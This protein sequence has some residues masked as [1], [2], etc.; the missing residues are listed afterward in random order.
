MMRLRAVQRRLRA[1]LAVTG[2]VAAVAAVILGGAAGASAANQY[3]TTATVSDLRFTTATIESGTIAQ[4]TGNWSLPDSPATPAGFTVHLPSELQGR[5]DHFP[6]IDPSGATMGQ[7]TVSSTE[8][9]CAI[10]TDYIRTHPRN[11][12]GTFT[13]AVSVQTIVTKPTP[14][15]Y[16]FD[17]STTT[18]TVT[19]PQ[20]CSSD[21]TFT[22]RGSGKVGYFHPDGN[23]IEWQVWVASGAVGMKGGEQVVVSDTPDQNQEL[24]DNINGTTY[25]W[26]GSTTTIAKDSTGKEQPVNF[27]P[28]AEGTYNHTAASVSFTA[29]QGRYYQVTFATRITD[30][31]AAGTYTNDASVTIDG[32]KDPVTATV[33]RQAGGG[34]GAGDAVGT[35]TWSKN[36]ATDTAA[37]GGSTWLVSGANNI[38]RTVTDNAQNDGNPA[39]GELETG[40]LPYGQYTLTEQTAPEGYQT[41]STPHAFTIDSDHTAINLG[42]ITNSRLPGSVSWTKTDQA[43]GRVLDGSTWTLTGPDGSTEIAD[44]G[45]RDTDDKSG[46]FTVTALPWGP[47]TLTEK[48]APA[49]YEL[50][51][52]PHTFTIAA[53]SLTANLGTITN[54]A[55]VAVTPTP[56]PTPSQ[57]T[58]PARP[59][60]P[61]STPSAHPTMHVPTAAGPYVATGGSLD[62]PTLPWMIPTVILALGIAAACAAM[63]HLQH[64][65]TNT[66]RTADEER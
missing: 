47:Y 20:D 8:L 53:T 49:G 13:F 57:S 21:C 63:L 50:D 16:T 12:K 11:L 38:A 51:S 41:D 55:T 10:D 48:T 44:N 22:G 32:D 40:E 36:D 42:A 28:V 18:A 34:T 60:H 1:A 33:V 29:E 54:T 56:T 15:T 30:A 25:A 9:D 37:I 64:G 27:T 26:L 6:L 35:V 2:S 45:P 24:I 61:G 17:G 62:R 46:H 14:T 66:A 19:P 65:R 52:T 58:N 31:G 39:V 7:C 43:N 3:T 23:W 4:L 59:A 5:T